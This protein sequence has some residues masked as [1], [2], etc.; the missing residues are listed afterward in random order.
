MVPQRLFQPITVNGMELKNRI[1]MTALQTNYAPQGIATPTF[2]SF[3]WERAEGG[4]GLVIVG[5]ARFEACGAAG[6]DFLSLEDDCFLP[7]LRI[8]TEG[9]HAR[10]AKTAVQLYHAGRYTKSK[11]LPDGVSALAPSAVYSPYTRETAREATAEE[12]KQ[13]VRRWAEGADRAKRAGFDGVEIVG[14]AGYLISQFLSPLTNLRTDEYGGSWE[15]RT[16]F[17]LEVL[18]AVRKAVGPEFPILFRIAGNDFVPGSNTN[19]EA[20]AFAA[21]LERHG[22]DLISV[23]GGWHETRVPQLP[24]EVPPAGFAYL[25]EAVKRA[26]SIPVIASNRIADPAAAELVLALE[27][28]DLVGMAR[29][30]I[31]DPDWPQKAEGDR[32]GEIRP[33]VACNQGCLA[34]TFFGKPIRCLVNAR[35]GGETKGLSPLAATPKHILVV[36]GGPAGMEFALRA[37]NRGHQIELWERSHRLGGQLHMAAVPPGKQEFQK[38]I[39][40]YERILPLAGVKISLDREARCNEILEQQFDVVVT[41]TGIRPKPCPLPFTAQQPTVV[42]AH[43]VLAGRVVPG[44]N[45]VILGGGAVGCETAR[46]L[47]RQGTLSPQQLYFLAT[48]HAEQPEVLERLLKQSSRNVSI[49]EAREKIGSGFDPGCGWP[50]IDDLKRLSVSVYTVAQVHAVTADTVTIRRGRE[51]HAE[52][53]TLPCDTLV[54]AIGSLPEQTLHHKLRH[55]GVETYLLGDALRPARAMDAI[56]QAFDLAARI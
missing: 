6:P 43:D 18:D 9:M 7:E 47:A 41:A 55:A 49:V 54:L 28:A 38:L 35:A 3:Y 15:N 50:V 2:R 23:T 51:D 5:G 33:C 56:H 30:L 25:A 19:R 36:G 11:Y 4:A 8:F 40:Y 46:Y 21:L 39:A 37:A 44:R 24:G 14:S 27:Q 16:R 32:A 31:A 53:V 29:P 34:G 48:N 45:T 52:S 26:V 13:I 1:V 12:L 22:A 10:G 42:S 20:V 17:P